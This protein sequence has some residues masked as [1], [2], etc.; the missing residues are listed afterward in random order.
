MTCG[1]SIALSDVAARVPRAREEVKAPPSQAGGPGKG[2]K[3]K[4][5]AGRKSSTAVSSTA[6]GPIAL[7]WDRPDG[8][9]A[10]VTFP[11]ADDNPT[12]FEDFMSDCLPAG[13]GLQGEDVYDENVRKALAMDASLFATNLCPYALGIV[14]RIEQLLLPNVAGIGPGGVKNGGFIRAELYKI[15]V[16][17]CPSRSDR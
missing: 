6:A 11:V 8:S 16:S 5:K 2:R 14:D 3:K 13:F 17:K 4:G 15:N 7:W 1:G 12:A 10:K 9:A